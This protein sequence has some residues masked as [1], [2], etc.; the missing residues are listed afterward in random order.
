MTEILILFSTGI[1]ALLLVDPFYSGGLTKVGFAKG[2]VFFLGFG[3]LLFHCFG[4]AV[5]APERFA[6][7]AREV[8][9]AWWPLLLLS[10]FICSGSIYARAVSDVRE[11]FLN[12]GLGMLFLP[13]F[14]LAIRSSDRPM[15]P[16]K[17]LAAIYVAVV[18]GT[19]PI[20]VAGIHDFHE[21][22]F[23]VIPIGTYWVCAPRFSLWRAV[24]GLALIGA[25]LFSFKNTTFL[26]VTL[27]LSACV[28]VWLCRLS[29]IRD[30]LAVVVA[31]MVIVPALIAAAGA[32]GYAWWQH[33]EVL[34]SGNLEYRTEMYGIAW[35]TFLDSP[36]WG[37]AFT[38]ASVVYFRLFQ[39]QTHTQYLPTHSDLLDLLAHGGV[40]AALLWLLVAWRLL[41][42]A[43]FSGRALATPDPKADLR[44][45]QWL[46]VLA[47]IQIGAVVTYAINPVMISPVYAFWTWGSGGVLWALYRELAGPA[48][49]GK[50]TRQAD[51]P[52]P[53]A[54]RASRA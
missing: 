24:L 46:G 41:T 45:F 7:A 18:L 11:S 4:R 36:V 21:S 35:R 14:A 8:L 13:L 12:V 15:L 37:T 29:R 10:V 3:S 2:L 9:A 50:L 31:A 25:C 47:L 40:L 48:L 1:S 17:W 27:S 44:P 23:I 5:V 22:I 30:R 54:S 42:I 19:L 43:W 6:A 33:R 28:L 32:V 53:F 16:M 26:L 49:P 38:D 39:V 52:R 20:L 51:I 34:P